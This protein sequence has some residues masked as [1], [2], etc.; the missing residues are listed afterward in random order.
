MNIAQSG[1]AIMAAITSPSESDW[2][3]TVVLKSNRVIKYQ[4]SPG[5]CAEDEAL[6]FTLHRLRISINDIADASVVRKRDVIVYKDDIEE[7]FDRLIK[8][9]KSNERDHLGRLR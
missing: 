4:L 1:A 9:I 7:E 3:V 2:I 8:R 5:A 6:G